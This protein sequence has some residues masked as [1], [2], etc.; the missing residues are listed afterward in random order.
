MYVRV[1]VCIYIYIYT[2][3]YIHIYIYIYIYVRLVSGSQAA[4][5]MPMYVFVRISSVRSCGCLTNWRSVYLL[6]SRG[7]LWPTYVSNCPLLHIRYF[8][9]PADCWRLP[10]SIHLMSCATLLTSTFSQAV[11]LGTGSEPLG[12]QIFF[13]PHAHLSLI[14]ARGLCRR[15]F[16][17]HLR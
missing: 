3:I 1:C 10:R 13:D 5:R 12:P 8:R 16:H 11:G 17:L 7:L 14:T 4:A 15:R 9:Q 6:V 2:Y